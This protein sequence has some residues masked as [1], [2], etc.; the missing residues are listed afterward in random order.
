MEVSVCNQT[1][2]NHQK[3]MGFTFRKAKWKPSL[4]PKQKKKL[5]WAEEKQWWAVDDWMKVK[6]NNELQICVG[7]DAATF[8]LCGLDLWRRWHA[9]D[10]GVLIKS[11]KS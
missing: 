4:M 11:G 8:I 5:Q 10:I 3:G 6:F 2:R 9:E 7:D 1:K